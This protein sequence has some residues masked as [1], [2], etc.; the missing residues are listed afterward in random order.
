MALGV[1]AYGWQHYQ[2]LELGYR[3]EEANKERTLLLKAREKLRGEHQYLRSSE[4]IDLI[5]RKR[6]NMT[7]AAPGQVQVM[8]PA[9]TTSGPELAARQ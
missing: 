9:T 1:L 3:I 2:Y 8:T 5:A 7:V 4:R 6:L